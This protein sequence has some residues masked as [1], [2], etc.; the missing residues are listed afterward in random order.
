MVPTPDKSREHWYLWLG[1]VE[2]LGC[3]VVVGWQ[4]TRNN[5]TDG[6]MATTIA[7]AEGMEPLIVVLA[8]ATVILV[9][10]PVV[11]AERYLKRRFT[12]G[13]AEGKA[14][15]MAE[16]R[17]AIFR[18]IESH[19]GKVFTTEELARLLDEEKREQP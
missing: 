6:P 12:E 17:A 3:L 13:K 18:V 5:T 2:L 11:L 8:V 10:G 1:L 16:E 15:G 4:E 9:E 7:I 19:P 14:E